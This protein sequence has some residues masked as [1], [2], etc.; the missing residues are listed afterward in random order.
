LA[1]ANPKFK[2]GGTFGIGIEQASLAA[3]VTV[4]A[5]ADTRWNTWMQV[6][7]RDGFFEVW[8]GTVAQ[9]RAAAAAKPAS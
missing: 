1:K 2:S 7:Q 9:I 3:A 6:N 8:S 5:L 4:P